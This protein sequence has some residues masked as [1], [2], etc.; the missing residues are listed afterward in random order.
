MKVKDF[1]FLTVDDQFD[2]RHPDW[3]RAYEYPAIIEA[4]K[5]YFG[6]DNDISIHNTSCGDHGTTAP[7]KEELLKICSE[8]RQSDIVR[9]ADGIDFY[10]IS[11]PC[12]SQYDAVI[13]V[14]T[15][16]EL[17]P[18]QHKLALKCL[19]DQVKEGGLAVFTFDYPDVD[20]KIVEQWCGS[21]CESSG[22]LLNGSNSK[23]P[24]QQFSHLNVVMLV[25]AKEKGG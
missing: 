14:S 3:S 24:F 10:D 17:P 12:D 5:G 6:Q 21:L 13:N 9:Y 2:E 1:R 18:A 20:L 7:F 16:E 19:W 23:H 15:L 8:F 11:T 4:V 22:T 25:V